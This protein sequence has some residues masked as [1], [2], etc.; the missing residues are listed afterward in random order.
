MRKTILSLAMVIAMVCG[1]TRSADVTEEIVPETASAL[2]E[3]SEF[4]EGELIVE[5]S[6]EAVAAIESGVA[7][8]A[9]GIAT[10]FEAAGV[11]SYER[12]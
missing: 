3:E 7:T 12:L 10:A 9:G 11:L 6:E 8:K 5:L 4:I 2:D 1:C